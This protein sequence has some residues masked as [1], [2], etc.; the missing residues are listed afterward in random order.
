MARYMVSWS[1]NPSAWPTDPKEVLAALEAATGGGDQ[2][3]G[4]GAANEIGWFTAQDGYAI[5]EADSK[6]SVL[7]MVQGFFPFFTQDVREIVSWEAGKNA[8]LDSA[9]QAAS[10]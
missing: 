10:R 1:A 4:G 6:A 2:L 5:F 8:I 3:L 7:G 9:R